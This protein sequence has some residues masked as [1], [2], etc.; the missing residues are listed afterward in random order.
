MITDHPGGEAKMDT[1]KQK[2]NSSKWFLLWIAVWIMALM[3]LF[4]ALAHG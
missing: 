3:A 1:Q 2:I 4:P